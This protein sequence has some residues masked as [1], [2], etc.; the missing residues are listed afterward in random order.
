MV[1]L[2]S[3]NCHFM[4]HVKLII[5]LF[6][7]TLL[8]SGESHMAYFYS[9]VAPADQMIP[10]QLRSRGVA[11][12]RGTVEVGKKLPLLS[13]GEISQQVTLMLPPRN[14]EDAPSQGGEQVLCDPCF[15]GAINMALSRATDIKSHV[16]QVCNQPMMV[17]RAH[18]NKK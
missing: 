14:Y 9:R 8:G 12:V 15:I 3:F 13:H 7:I 10:R 1:R 2:I 17:T 18:D 11:M 5:P 4:F 16:L 6:D